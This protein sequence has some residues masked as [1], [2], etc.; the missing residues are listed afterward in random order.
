MA[1]R[2]NNKLKV[3]IVDPNF[4]K[5]KMDY[6]QLALRFFPFRQDDNKSPK[7]VGDQ[8][9]SYFDGA[10]TVHTVKFQEF[11]ES[12]LIAGSVPLVTNR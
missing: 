6:H 1:I 2:H 11:L 10:F 9:Y 3:T 7:K 12:Q 5:N 8:L 4:I